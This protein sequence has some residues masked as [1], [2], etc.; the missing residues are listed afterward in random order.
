MPDLASTSVTSETREAINLVERLLHEVDLIRRNE[1]NTLSQAT[2]I[3]RDIQADLN[4]N[5]AQI[6]QNVSDSAMALYNHSLG[7][8]NNIL[9]DLQDPNSEDAL[10][11]YFRTM[12]PL[13]LLASDLIKL[14]HE[15][16][17]NYLSG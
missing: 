4:N 12:G 14:L 10:D 5:L 11:R 3:F 8:V 2:N 6:Q 15:L 9:T 16:D 1:M 7:I 17:P 13:D